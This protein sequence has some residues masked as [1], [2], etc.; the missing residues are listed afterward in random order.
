MIYDDAM[1]VETSGGERVTVAVLDSGVKVD[2]LDLAANIVDCKD[3]TLRRI[4]K[5][6]SDNAGHGTHVAGTILANGGPDGSGIY[7]VAPNAKLMAIKVCGGIYCWGDD[8][9]EGIRYAADNGA[10]IVSMSL[11][12]DRPDP[13][14]LSAVDYAVEKG[15]L[16]IAA[17]GNDGR[18]F[19][20]KS[21]HRVKLRSP[22]FRTVQ[23]RF[24]PEQN[25]FFFG[26]RT[27]LYT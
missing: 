8:I 25:E 11:G 17:A 22:I 27:S 9:A 24:L 5:G 21:G 4:K 12:G 1:L 6:C 19:T 15:V 10:N 13:Q 3:T 16:V 18:M 2:H 20:P 14:V 7:G 23:G 26:C